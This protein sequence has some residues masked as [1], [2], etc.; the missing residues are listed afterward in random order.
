MCFQGVAGLGRSASGSAS[1]SATP[2]LQQQQAGRG[3]LLD[4]LVV[5]HQAQAATALPLTPALTPAS[6]VSTPAL[7]ASAV[8]AAAP[9]SVRRWGKGE[10]LEID[11][12]LRL[13]F[14]EKSA[15]VMEL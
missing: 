12:C 13:D 9:A 4:G 2:S 14:G 10:S 3:G 11:V 5:K 7:L 1:A 8:A 15:L 6:G